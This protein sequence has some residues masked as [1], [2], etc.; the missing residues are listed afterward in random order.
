MVVK[1]HFFLPRIG[2][3]FLALQMAE[4]CEY[5]WGQVSVLLY[6]TQSGKCILSLLSLE[7]G[8]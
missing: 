7:S 6:R 8:V 3:P 1:C 4:L 5:L 2:T